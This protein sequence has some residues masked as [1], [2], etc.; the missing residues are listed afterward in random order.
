[1]TSTAAQKT[2]IIVCQNI[3]KYYGTGAARVHALSGVNLEIYPGE[4]RMLMGPSGSGK[5]TLV[6]II[7]G[8]LTQ[9]EGT[10]LVNNIDLNHL[11]DKDKTHYRGKNIGFV[12]QSFN[13]I[14]HLA[15]EENISIPLILLGTPK[16]K[17]LE[18][19]RRLLKDVG[20]EDKIGT[21]PTELSGGQQQRVAIARAMVHEP[22]IIVCDEPTSFLDIAS[23]HVIMKLLKEMVSK[24]GITLIVITHDSRI[25]EYADKI[26]HM[27]DGKILD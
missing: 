21:Y 19:A 17:A 14:P 10:C 5:T 1:M 16:N 2:P 4:L 11:P 12:F 27:E 7:A 13:L 6:S 24:K 23:G 15:C 22:S 3:H 26:D 25:M 9:N 20:L 18:R 8:I